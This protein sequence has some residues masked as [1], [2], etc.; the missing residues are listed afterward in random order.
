MLRKGQVL[1]YAI[2]VTP[3]GRRGR[4]SLLSEIENRFTIINMR[5]V[6]RWTRL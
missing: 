4:R 2:Y 1:K 3:I 6:A 5:C